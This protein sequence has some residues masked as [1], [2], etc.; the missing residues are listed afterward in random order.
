L[1]VGQV[2]RARSPRCL[3]LVVLSVLPAALVAQI[4]E[5]KVIFEGK[6][7]C[8]RC[9]S[10]ESRGGSLGPD[11]SEIGLK[12]TPESLRLS[13]ID[14]SADIPREYLTL[15]ITTKQNQRIEGICLNEDDI[16]IQLRDA[17]GSPRSFLKSNLSEVQREERSLMPSYASKLSTREIESLVEYLRDLKGSV[18]AIPRAREIGPLTRNTDW[19]T[20]ANRDAQER[21]EMLVDSLQISPGA[22]VVDLGAGAGYF[23]WRLAQRVGLRGKVIAVDIQQKMLDLVTLEVKNRGFTNVAVVLGTER[24]PELPAAAVD[25]VL[26]ANVYH[27]F[28]EPEAMM[29]AVRRCLKPHGRVVVIEYAEENTDDPVAGLYTMTLPEIRSEIEAAGFQLDRILD[30]LPMQHGLIFT[31]SAQNAGRK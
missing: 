10:I 19:L 11:L 29:A 21:P 27:E 30:F 2:A 18:E 17:E 13:I 16:S 8:V 28:S 12:R 15:V 25:L 5:G 1:I 31:P 20:R 7:G 26:I 9:H 14:P 3:R 24:D 6:G 4:S 23:T 22:T